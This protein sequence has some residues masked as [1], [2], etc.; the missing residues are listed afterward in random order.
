MIGAAL[1]IERTSR[2]ALQWLWRNRARVFAKRRVIQARRKVSDRE[3]ARWF[4]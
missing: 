3:L 4:V 1:T 2:P